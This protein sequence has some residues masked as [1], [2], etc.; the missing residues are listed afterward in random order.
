MTKELIG[1]GGLHMIQRLLGTTG[2]LSSLR[3]SMSPCHSRTRWNGNFGGF[4]VDKWQSAILMASR[5]RTGMVRLVVVVSFGVFGHLVLE[6]SAH[7]GLL[8]S[9]QVGEL[10][11]EVIWF[12]FPLCHCSDT[13]RRFFCGRSSRRGNA[14]D[15]EQALCQNQYLYW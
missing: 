12:V 10:I 15:F 7:G 3:N 1:T 8:S 9:S 4:P 13:R 5:S 11:S 2:L 6:A 14:A